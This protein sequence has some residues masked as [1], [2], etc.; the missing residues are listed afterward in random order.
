VFRDSRGVVHTVSSADPLEDLPPDAARALQHALLT[1]GDIGSALERCDAV[2][3]LVERWQDAFFA[4]LPEDIDLA[5]EAEWAAKA[6][7]SLEEFDEEYDDD[8]VEGDD[9]LG[10][11][12]LAPELELLVDDDEDAR[13]VLPEE[14]VGVLER[15]LLLLPL[16]TRLEALVAAGDLVSGWSDLLADHEKLLGHL[17]LR[18]GG[19]SGWSDAEAPPAHEEL[20]DEHAR[21]HGLSG[22]GHLPLAA[23]QA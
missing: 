4:A 13:A 14:L 15:E 10:L 5:E 7:L 11:S 16:R 8:E 20:V 12:S 23:E 1:P 3:D 22:P 6:G 9:D 19:W 21:R 18:H 17:V 2:R